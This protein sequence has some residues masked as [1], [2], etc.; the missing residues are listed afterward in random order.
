M[1]TVLSGPGNVL[2]YLLLMRIY[3][4]VAY[5][6]IVDHLTSKQIMGNS[7]K[8]NKMMIML[9]SSEV[10]GF[11]TDMSTTNYIYEG[12][13]VQTERRQKFQYGILVAYVDVLKAFDLVHREALWDLLRL[14]G[15]PVQ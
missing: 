15:M 5:L 12:L 1:I 7:D 4:N 3:I 9:Q 11:T 2:P 14:C 13:I 8:L 6:S 10:S